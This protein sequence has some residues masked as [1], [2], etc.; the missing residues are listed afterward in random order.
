[1][2][3]RND[4]ISVEEMFLQKIKKLKIIISLYK[5]DIYQAIVDLNFIYENYKNLSKK[6]IKKWLNI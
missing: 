6:K 2:N 4:N 3:L 5:Q 1:M